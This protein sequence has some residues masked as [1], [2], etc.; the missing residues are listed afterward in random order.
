MY[1]TSF[2]ILGRADSRDAL[3]WIVSTRVETVLERR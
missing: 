1:V 2:E 3:P